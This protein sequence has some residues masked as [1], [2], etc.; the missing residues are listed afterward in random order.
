MKLSSIQL[1]LIL[2][3]ISLTVGLSNHIWH[4]DALIHTDVARDLLVL[5]E[6]V[7]NKQLTLIGPRSSMPGVF[8]GPLWYYVNLIPFYLF[9]GNPVLMSWFWWSLSV[10]AALAFL[11]CCNRQ[12]KNLTLSLLAT[13]CFVLIEVPGS[14]GPTNNYLAN[15]FSFFPFF[16]WWSWIINPSFILSIIGWLSIGILVQFQMAYAFPTALLWGPVFLWKI[17]KDKKYTQLVSVIFFFIPL[18]TFILFDLRHGWLQVR[19]F[20]SYMQLEKSDQSF[21]LKI[22]GRLK[23]SLFDAVNIFKLNKFINLSLIVYIFYLVKKSKDKY[24]NNY[25]LMFAYWYF[26]WWILSFV[27]SGSIWSFYYDPFAGILLFVFV[28]LSNKIRNVKLLFI[29]LSLFLLISSYQYFYYNKDRF[30]SSSWKLLSQIAS[31]SLSEK[32]TGYFLY[33]QDQF[34]YPLKYAFSYYSKNNPD[35]GAKPYIKAPIT[36]LVKSTDDPNNPWSTSKDWQINKIKIDI[37][38]IE[39][40]NY[41]HGY[42]FEKYFLNEDELSRPVDE[43]LVKGLEF[44]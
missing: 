14:A 28:V 15:L 43:N 41:S 25:V 7:E 39:V 8:H 27:F 32:N 34:A 33:S 37:D 21:Y 3:L 40:K 24:L 29:F 13:I 9:N 5:E 22:L 44:R 20:I 26:G 16:I 17:F 2:L 36:I 1:F 42:T 6:I 11:Y 18:V 35:S 4:G 12:T 31:E 23:Q 10:F 19:S 38:P 30:N